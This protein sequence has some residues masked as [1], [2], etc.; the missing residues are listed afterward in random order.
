MAT[1]RLPLLHELLLSFDFESVTLGRISREANEFRITTMHNVKVGETQK[2]YWEDLTNRM[3][4]EIS[5]NLIGIWLRFRSA[6]AFF[7]LRFSLPSEGVPKK[8]GL[9]GRFQSRAW[10]D[11]RGGVGGQVRG[12][13]PG[14]PMGHHDGSLL[15]GS[16]A[17]VT[18]P[19]FLVTSLFCRPD[20]GCVKAGAE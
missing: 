9:R 5:L 13:L 8:R 17:F 11:C 19:G 12:D 14:R 10:R 20:L 1:N 6:P 2:K 7:L 15:L 3:Q 18:L 16:A 4:R